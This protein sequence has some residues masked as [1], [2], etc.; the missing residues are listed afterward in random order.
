MENAPRVVE[1][2]RGFFTPIMITPRTVR[3]IFCA[4]LAT[5]LSDA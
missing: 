1:I 5:L 3:V 2:Q 4:K